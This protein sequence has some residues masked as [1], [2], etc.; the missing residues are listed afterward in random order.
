MR[1]KNLSVK[2]FRLLSSVNELS[3]EEDITIIIGKNNTGKTS[4]F[5][6]VELFISEKSKSKLSFEDFSQSSYST[7][8]ELCKEYETMKANPD[9]T[10]EEK[11]NIVKSI[12]KRTPSIELIIEFEYN[13]LRDKITFLSEF[14]SDIDDNRNDACALIAFEPINTINVYE[15]FIKISNKTTFIDYLQKNINALY[16]IN[17]YAFDK[18]NEY[19][20]LIDKGYVYKLSQFIDIKGIR[21]L[22]ILD[23]KKDDKNRSLAAC[24][25]QYYGDK[26]Q[27]DSDIE[28]LNSILKDVSKSFK[29]QYDRVLEK[30]LKN[31]RLFGAT[32][33]LS[34]PEISIEAEFDAQE[35]IRR[36]IHYYYKKEEGINFPENYNGLGYSNLIYLILEIMTF[37]KKFKK[38]IISEDISG[39]KFQNAKVLTIFLEE[40]ECHMHPQMQQI[41]IQG[42]KQL[43]KDERNNNIDIQLIIT[44]HSSHIIAETAINNNKGFS[45]LRYFGRKGEDHFIK[46]FNYFKITDA[47]KTQ[48]MRFL[49]KYLTL[50]KCDLFFADKAIIVEG[51]TERLLLPQMIN[52]V[53]KTL[54]NEYVTVLE[55]GGAYAHKFKELIEFIQLKTLIITDLDSV[56]SKGKACPVANGISTSNGVLKEWLPNMSLISDLINCPTK[57]K[58][59]NDLIRVAY[60]TN[61]VSDNYI[62]R[63]F[64]EAFIRANNDLL[65]S[66]HAENGETYHIKNQFSLFKKKKIATLKNP[67]IS[68][69]SDSAKSNF[70]FD[71]MCFNEEKYRQWIVP[72]YIKEGLIWL[73]E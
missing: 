54:K 25:A 23:D 36:N 63:S 14:I 60:Q 46:D 24:F 72:Q 3:I 2:N 9:L 49:Y 59:A 42:I 58:I 21:A 47:S 43:I 70:A 38:S 69:P 13:K 5:E 41:F 35:A 55:I 30:P 12:V 32:K 61:E 27:T 17:C 18:I 31:I 48:T 73:A 67:Y 62:A 71:I 50:Q 7:F 11:N 44:T 34:I 22:R 56:N 65:T 1:I 16:S 15:K 26:E 10:D 39:I 57:Q 64:E 68:S 66:T 29:V 19:K 6:I 53:A 45:Q 37:I 20:R 51:L 40:P 8:K 52:K 33:K 4:L 28:E